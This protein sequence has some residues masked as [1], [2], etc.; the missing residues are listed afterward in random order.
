ML[1]YIYYPDQHKPYNS[2]KYNALKNPN[3]IRKV[4]IVDDQNLFAVGIQQL[5]ATIKNV[6]VVGIIDNG[7][8][9]QEKVEILKPD[10]LLLDLNLPG[11]NGFDIL[12][13]I[14][15]QFPQLIIAILTM[16]KEPFLIKKAEELKANAYLTK[17]VTLS[18]LEEVILG[19]ADLPFYSRYNE[20]AK[21][22]NPIKEDHFS[23]VAQLTSREMEV[24][25]LMLDDK[26]SDEIAKALFVSKETIK[27]HRKNIFKKL[28]IQKLSEL[29]KMAYEM[30]WK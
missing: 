22:Q 30:G 28:E 3:A 16:Y 1:L 18:E 8:R 17:D 9:I 15:S 7:E 25:H 27:T 2:M 23:N 29:I 10:V 5:L 6:V 26:S 4:L 12:K 14:R 11:K 21:K 24:I 13:E 20:E 19:T